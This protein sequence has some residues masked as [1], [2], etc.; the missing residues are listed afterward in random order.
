MATI[1]EIIVSRCADFSFEV[2]EVTLESYIVKS[3][4]DGGELYAQS[5]AKKADAIMYAII[6]LLLLMPDVSEGQFSKK[7]NQA[8]IISFYKNLCAELDLPD[9]LNPQPKIVNKSN[10][11]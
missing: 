5:N 4:T 3:G 2:S 11:W 7:Y 6:P 10:I 9:K 1:K 8:G